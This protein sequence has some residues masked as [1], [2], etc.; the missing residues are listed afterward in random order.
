MTVILQKGLTGGTV[1]VPPSKSM[2]HRYLICAALA[3]EGSESVI[4]RPGRSDDIAATAESLRALGAEITFS[5]D[6]EE[7]RV[8]GTGGHFTAAPRTLFCGESAS[9]LRF[10]LPLCLRDGVPTRF[11]CRG[12][13]AERP[14]RDYENLLRPSGIAVERTEDGFSVC[15]TLTPGSFEIAAGN[16][17]Q[18]VSG[19]L[20]ALPLLGGESRLSL[21]G[22]PVSRGYV[23]LT[24]AVLREAGIGIERTEKEII[25]PGSRT[26]R[27]LNV[28][29]EGDES[30]AAVFRTLAAL[31]PDAPIVLEGLNPA[32]PQPDRVSAEYLAALRA[33]TPELSLRD[34]PDLGPVLI[35]AAAALHGANFRWA[36]RLRI[37]ESDRVDAMQDALNQFGAVAWMMWGGCLFVPGA[38]LHKPRRP[39]SPHGDHRIAMALAVLCTLTGGTIEDAECVSKSLPEFFDLLSDLGVQIR[40][41]N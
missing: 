26:Y 8:R 12:R 11:V 41:S 36:D 27:P 22:T 3:P 40:K 35:A 21:L 4:R 24:A 17:S 29:V 38:K 28:T 25:I 18:F 6:G 37:K 30:A 19:L 10:L 32:S 15:G 14:I 16:S 34:C 7:C 39:L 9:T 1:R 5:P 20:F 23:D 31:H 13:L 33:G 2:A